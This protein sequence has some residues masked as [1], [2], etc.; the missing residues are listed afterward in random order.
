MDFGDKKLTTAFKLCIAHYCDIHGPTPLMVTEGSRHPCSTCFESFDVTLG[1]TS[2]KHGSD[3]RTS[4]SG[5]I[6]A[7]H[8]QT[9]VALKDVSRDL[10]LGPSG[11]PPASE[12]D[13]GTRRTTLRYSAGR[14][15]SNDIKNNNGAA[16]SALD[17]PP[18]SPR[19]I[20]R[21]P[22][23][24]SSFRRTYDDV[25]T[26]KQGPCDN[27]AMTL[28]P[29][30]NAAASASEPIL[31]TMS[32]VERVSGPAGQASPPD[33]QTSNETDDE[34]ESSHGVRFRRKQ[35]TP[36]SSQNTSY[37]STSIS[38]GRSTYHHLHNVNYTSS[39]EPLQPDSFT[40]L[41]ASC[42]RALSFEHTARPPS[43]WNLN[44]SPQLDS[45]VTTQS[46]GCAVTG[47]PIF[48][49]DAKAGY[50]TGYLF[51]IPDLHARGHKRLYAF[52]ALSTHKE[53]VAMKT[54]SL[55]IQAFEVLA[56]WIQQLAEAEA[57]R[58]STNSSP[59]SGGVAHGGGAQPQLHTS[60]LDRSSSGFMQGG[61]AFTRRT[62]YGPGISS[63]KA[64]GLAEIVGQPDFFITLHSKFVELLFQVA[65][66]LNS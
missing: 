39:H 55:F 52:L 37:S 15:S 9:S 5:S 22:L 46:P 7:L 14:S 24:D 66:A 42:L 57:E 13:T 36:G 1:A 47:G 44:S 60:A 18:E 28:P 3:K 43:S 64:R 33:S 53:R 10:S 65:V 11:S 29:R 40:L 32:A 19:P 51:R 58:T 20:H 2:P 54:F 49:G 25:V 48:F 30:Q 56:S 45:F 26:K 50:T 8:S 62:G 12:P 35:A 23:R 27:C 61:S 31:R 38:S 34:G 41:R 21:K 17:T 63:L 16:S 59:R 4:S 6:S